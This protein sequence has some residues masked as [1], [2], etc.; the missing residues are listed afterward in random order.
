VPVAAAALVLVAAATCRPVA[1]RAPAAALR[2]NLLGFAPDAPKAAVLC[3]REG[4]LPAEFVVVDVATGAT[5]LG[6]EPVEPAGPFGPCARTAR[7]AFDTLRA[8]GRYRV[9]AGDLASPDFP[10][11]PDVYERVADSL[12][13]YLR[14]QRS[15]FNPLFRDSVH[16]DTDGILV[17]HERAG[18]FVPVAGGW[19]DAADYLQYVTT[20]ATTTFHLLKAWRDAP[21]VFRDRFDAAGLPGANGVPD[22]LDEGRW[23]LEWLLRMHPE[24]DL[25]LHQIGDDRDHAFLDLPTTD[26]SDYGWGRGGPRP[27]YPCT[28]A[29]QGL[30]DHRN[31]S[32]GQASAAGK[33]AAAFALGA[34]VFAERDAPFAERLGARA[35][36]A[37]RLGIRSPGVCQTAPARAPYFYEEAD[38]ADDMELAAGLLHELT[39]EPALLAEAHAF[40]AREPVSRWMGADTARHYEWFPWHNHGH[41]ELWRLSTDGATRDTAA[42]WYARGLEAVVARAGHGFRV[43]IPFIWCSNDLMVALATQAL[44]WERMTGD[45]RY[46]AYQSA[47]FDWLFGANPW[48]RSFVIGLG[49]EG[50]S[51]ADPH[52]VVAREL[53]VA[54]QTGGLVDGPVYRSIF[55]SLRFVELTGPDLLAPWNTGSIVY[56]DDWGDYATNEPILDG[57]GALVYLAAMIAREGAGGG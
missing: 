12:L 25:I 2:L 42:A 13:H 20:S 46:R 50:A 54:T 53:G 48:G 6:P 7:L 18:E 39:G 26:S 10:V 14:Q 8:P 43:G 44:H 3:V 17:D 21:S 32:D 15:L 11:A 38:W 5:V 45:E 30:L 34:T 1:E 57:T 16:Q 29:P 27:V 40:G 28:G 47:A 4:A 9:V 49:G 56:H 51:P 37:Y 55:E 19:A 52:S 35:R 33:L 24:D 23:G 41:H 31:R 36:T 22:V